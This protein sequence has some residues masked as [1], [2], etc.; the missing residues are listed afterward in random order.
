MIN[1]ISC[2]IIAWM[3]LHP[4]CLICAQESHMER[5]EIEHL[6]KG[7]TVTASDSRPLAQA[8]VAI[9]Q[10]YGWLVDYEDPAYNPSETV[11]VADADWPLQ[12]KR[13]KSLRRPAGGS[14]SAHYPEDLTSGM[15]TD[16]QRDEVL[17]AVLDSY[18]QSG[19]PGTFSLEHTGDHRSAVIGRDNTG[20]AVLDAI[21][22]TKRPDGDAYETLDYILKAIQGTQGHKL[23]LGLVPTNALMQCDI[24]NDLVGLKARDAILSVLNNCHL[25]MVWQLLYD[26]D[27][28]R[29]L[30]N[31]DAAVLAYR[32]ASGRRQFTAAPE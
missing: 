21:I 3:I 27:Q 13:S 9:R 12:Y 10:E 19:N 4:G 25:K 11:E 20:H 1:A 6:S 16:A 14:F 30:L 5:A 32:D 8:V 31:L 24:K 22:T 23:G 15:R 2:A 29:F 17:K 7:A 18:R 28:D 26:V